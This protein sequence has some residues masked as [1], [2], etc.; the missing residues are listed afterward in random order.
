MDEQH[1]PGAA[2]DGRAGPLPELILN[3]VDCFLSLRA[4]RSNPESRITPWIATARSAPRDDGVDK[5]AGASITRRNFLL[6]ASAA[7]CMEDGGGH[8]SECRPKGPISGTFVQPWNPL[9]H[10][11]TSSWKALLGSLSELGASAIYLQWTGLSSGPSLAPA[12]LIEAC[13]ACGFKLHLGLWQGASDTELY[14]DPA[15]AAAEL[16]KRRNESLKLAGDYSSLV[17]SSPAFAGWYLPEEPNDLMLQHPGRAADWASH[18]AATVRALEALT[19][20]AG[21]AMSSYV[22]NRLGPAAF[23]DFWRGVWRDT[24]RLQLLLQDGYGVQFLPE[25]GIAPY[26]AELDRARKDAGGSLGLVVETF[27]QVAGEPIDKE[28]FRAKPTSISRL[29]RQ[30]DLGMSIPCLPMV[31]FTMTDYML[32]SRG[33]DAGELGRA[34]RVGFVAEHCRK[35][36]S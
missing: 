13:E 15:K 1:A 5:L 30:I 9:P 10:Y 8:G 32:G 12:K 27:Q 3:P 25:G 36:P 6:G 33:A 7:L 29:R 18:I 4:K 31:A 21:V 20:D 17:K 22:S 26:L 14:A 35:N 16:E 24:P 2:E 34:Y 23:A 11:S 28:P 19:P